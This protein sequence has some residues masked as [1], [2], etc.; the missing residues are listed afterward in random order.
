MRNSLG[1][2]RMNL[3]F[4]F[5]ESKFNSLS[6][7]FIHKRHGIQTRVNHHIHGAGCKNRTHHKILL[8]HFGRGQFHWNDFAAVS[9]IVRE[10]FHSR[11][12]RRVIFLAVAIAVSEP[13]FHCNYKVESNAIL[14]LTRLPQL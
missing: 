4:Y 10:L 7:F 12:W 5:E 8:H 11:S 3:I 13:A 2:V 9:A 14:M 1:I 6:L